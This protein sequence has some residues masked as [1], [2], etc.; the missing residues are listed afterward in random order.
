MVELDVI[1][2]SKKAFA[3]LAVMDYEKDEG[4]SP[5]QLIF[6]N[7]FQA[8]VNVKRISEQE[9][10]LL[11]VEEFKKEYSG[12][13]YSIETPTKEKYKFGKSYEDIKADNNGQ[14]A[15]LDMCVFN[16]NENKYE[17]ILS[18]EFKHKN[19]SIKSIGKDILKLMNEQ[20]N[21]A[22]TILLE[23]TNKGTFCNSSKTGIFDKLCKLF[24][25]FKDYS[26]NW[27]ND[28]TIDLIILSLKQK[29]LIHRKINKTDFNNLKKIFYIQSGCGDITKINGN[30]W[31]IENMKSTVTDFVSFLDC[32]RDMNNVGE[33]T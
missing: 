25:D 1:K 17:R 4:S 21:G 26:M 5:E 24:T 6:P 12:L 20:Q 23:N 3:R 29:I 10:R 2:I 8:K 11:F 15:L 16:R 19:A 7:K 22:F 30:G 18:I 31:K 13:F 28:K 33:I 14:S 27:N 9:L 32:C